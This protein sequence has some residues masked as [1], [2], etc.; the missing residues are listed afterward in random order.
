MKEGL[1]SNPGLNSSVTKR[2]N[3]S[4]PPFS[5]LYRIFFLNLPF[6]VAMENEYVE[7][8]SMVSGI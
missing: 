3:T 1:H 8:L 5:H 2:L 4:G 6:R 7:V